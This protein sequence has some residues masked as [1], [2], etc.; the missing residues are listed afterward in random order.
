MRTLHQSSAIATR[1]LQVVASK[2][3][4]CEEDHKRLMQATYNGLKLPQDGQAI[5][6]SNGQITTPD[7]PDRKSVV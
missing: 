1:N 2:M 3:K 4:T 6:Y 7:H 5:E